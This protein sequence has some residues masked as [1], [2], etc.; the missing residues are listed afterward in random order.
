V[1]HRSSWVSS[2]AHTYGCG[3]NAKWGRIWACQLF[4]AG[5]P[6]GASAGSPPASSCGQPSNTYQ[7][8]LRQGHRALPAFESRGRATARNEHQIIAVP[9]TPRLRFQRRRSPR[10]GDEGTNNKA[11]EPSAQPGAD[12]DSERGYFSD[13]TTHRFATR[14]APDVTR[15]TS[16]ASLAACRDPRL[17]WSACDR[18]SAD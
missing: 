1:C 7:P 4:P 16:A 2:F 17:P 3:D 14:D 15:N 6:C 5:L 11:V 10:C 12:A 13:T 18:S 8:S 9:F